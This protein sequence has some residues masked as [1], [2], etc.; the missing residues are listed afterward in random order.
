MNEGKSKKKG[1]KLNFKYEMVRMLTAVLIALV[2]AMVI[3]LIASDEPLMAIKYLFL[4]PLESKRRFFNVLE[5]M[6]PLTFTGLSVTVMFKANQFNMISEGV[7]YVGGVIASIIVVSMKLPFVIHPL[8]SILIAGLVGGFIATIPSIIKLKWNASELVSSLMMNFI[9]FNL[10]LY[11]INNFFRDIN[12][13]AMASLPFEETGKLDIMFRGTRLHYGVLILLVTW[14]LTYLFINKTKLG[15]QLRVTGEN[16]KFAKYSG[17]KTTFIIILSQFVGGFIAAV[18]GATEVLGMYE[19]FKWQDLTNYGFDGIIVAILAKE[20]PQ[21]VPLAAFF[22]AYIRIG[23]DRM[24]NMT[25]VTFE[26]VA[27]LQGII[28]MLVAAKSFMGKY[29]QKLIEKEAN[30]NG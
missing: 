7:F 25:D 16:I 1:L 21:Y 10:G 23:A 15:Y 13:G 14:I 30:L 20:K 29:R 24:G 4:G 11:V 2:L 5:L 12:A 17:I 27:I 19:R 3:I 22:L 9:L 8:F 26:M 6:I 28:I 18:G